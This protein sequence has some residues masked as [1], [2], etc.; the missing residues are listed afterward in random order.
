MGLFAL[1]DGLLAR[2]EKMCPQNNVPAGGR[3][4]AEACPT[5]LL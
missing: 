2:R 4:Q 5:V 3:W 1:S